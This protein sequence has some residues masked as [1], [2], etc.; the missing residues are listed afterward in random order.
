VAGIDDLLASQPQGQ[1]SYLSRGQ[2]GAV[3]ESKEEGSAVSHCHTPHNDTGVCVGLAATLLIC[4]A[5]NAD[6]EGQNSS[7]CRSQVGTL[8]EYELDKEGH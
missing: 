1:C 8:V 6:Q 7:S 5:N 2:A 4:L 3:P